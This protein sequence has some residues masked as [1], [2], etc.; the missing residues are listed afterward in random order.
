M[1]NAGEVDAVAFSPDGKT[2]LTGGHDGTARF[3]DVESGRQLGPSLRHTD[4]VLSVAFHPDGK[5]VATGTKNGKVQRWHVPSLASQWKRRPDPSM[6]QNAN[7]TRARSSRSGS[8]LVGRAFPCHRHRTARWRVESTMKGPKLFAA[9]CA[10]LAGTAGLVVWIA[11]EQA[12]DPLV[13]AARAYGRDDWR[14][15]EAQA[16]LVLKTNSS[17]PHALRLLARTSARQGRDESAEAI[18]R[19]L[20]TK[21]MEAEDFFLLGRGLLGGGQVGPALASLGRGS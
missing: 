6:G 4:A 2:L 9:I 14:S 20:G 18:Y 5:S 17:D 7:G 3:W 16:R 21:F 13:Q 8:S 19:R 11:R 12:G 10:A 1:G 15:A